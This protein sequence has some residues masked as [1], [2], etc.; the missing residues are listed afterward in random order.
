MGGEGELGG[1]LVEGWAVWAAA[2]AALVVA[3]V[4]VAVGTAAGGAEVE[5]VAGRL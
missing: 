4:R 5:A 1:G 2:T 3:V